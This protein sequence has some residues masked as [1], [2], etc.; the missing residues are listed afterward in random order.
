M[1]EE[2]SDVLIVG[3]GLA[4]ATAASDL[5][6]RGLRITILEGRERVGG[7]GYFRPFAGTDQGLDF[8][9]SW[10]TPRAG[11]HTATVRAP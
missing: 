1:A 6:A 10:I 5:G 3:A 9:G 11:R 7:R 4:G 2:G 8:G